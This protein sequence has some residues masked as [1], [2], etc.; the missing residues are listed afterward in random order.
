MVSNTKIAGTSVAKPGPTPDI[1]KTR[2]KIL[3]ETCS[4]MTATAGKRDALAAI[5]LEGAESMPGCLSYVVARDLAD[6]DA[7]WITEVWESQTSHQAS[8]ALPTVQAAIA[9]GRPL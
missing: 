8:L 3:R 2:S 4:K 6:P 5:L 9:K 1:V 7:V